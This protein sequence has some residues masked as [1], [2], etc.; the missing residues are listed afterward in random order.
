MIRRA[1][2]MGKHLQEK[3]EASMTPDDFIQET[4]IQHAS[5]RKLST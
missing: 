4:T 1:M 3:A 2:S 5:D